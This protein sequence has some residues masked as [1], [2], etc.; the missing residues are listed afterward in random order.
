MIGSLGELAAMPG[1][2]S[3]PT[4]K[5]LIAAHGDFPI[6]KRGTN[7]SAYEFDLAAA[8]GFILGLQRQEEEVARQRAE[9]VRQFGLALLGDDA[10][11][12]V[13]ESVGL[14]PS[15]RLAMLQEELVAIKVAKERGELIR[16]ASIEAALGEV[17]IWFAQTGRTFSS[18]LAKR[19]DLSRDQIAAIDKLMEADQTELAARMEKM[20]HAAPDDQPGGHPPV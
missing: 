6:L 14:T 19:M 11:S 18:R 2:P 15:E 4:I 1:M 16:K 17:V 12:A 13:P 9:E 10:A 7:G 5:K 8:H 20:G 3:E